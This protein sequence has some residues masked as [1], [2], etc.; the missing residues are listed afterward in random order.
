MAMTGGLPLKARAARQNDWAM[1]R[2][3]TSS[4]SL[5]LSERSATRPAKGPSTSTGPNWATAS[6]P[7][8]TPLSV[9]FRTSSVWATRVSQLPIWEMSWPPKNSRKLRTCSDRKVSAPARRSRDGVG[10]AAGT[11]FGHAA[12]TAFGHAA[13]TAFGHAAG[14]AFGHAA[15]SRAVLGEG[16]EHVEGVGQPALGAGVEHVDPRRQP[17]RL[18]PAGLG[19][20]GRALAPTWP[21]R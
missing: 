19:Q 11:A 21:P 2:L 7:R 8:A 15:G 12:A 1:A 10:H 13:A 6:M 9:S 14:T 4:S 18:A 17:R 16:V 20:Q 5:R 3:W